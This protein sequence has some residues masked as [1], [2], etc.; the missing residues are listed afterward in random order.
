MQKVMK[1][2]QILSETIPVSQS[3]TLIRCKLCPEMLLLLSAR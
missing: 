2:S 1:V 3:S